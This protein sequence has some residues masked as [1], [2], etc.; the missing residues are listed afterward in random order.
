M[1]IKIR[2]QL[3]KRFGLGV[4]KNLTEE[5]LEYLYYKNLGEVVYKAIDISGIDNDK[6]LEEA[7]Q[8]AWNEYKT[9]FLKGLK[10]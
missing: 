7:R 8:K 9:E 10:V 4:I 1:D 2:Q 6:E 5:E 3:I